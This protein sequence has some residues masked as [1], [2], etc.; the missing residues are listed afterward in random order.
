MAGSFHVRMAESHVKS[1]LNSNRSTVRMGMGTHHCYQSSE[2]DAT[3]NQTK[4]CYCISF[5]TSLGTVLS[6]LQCALVVMVHARTHCFKCNRA[7]LGSSGQETEATHGDVSR[8]WTNGIAS[9][10]RQVLSLQLFPCKSQIIVSI[11]DM[12]CAT[13]GQATRP[14]PVLPVPTQ[15]RYTLPPL[16]TAS[17]ATPPTQICS[18][19]NGCLSRARGM[20]LTRQTSS[21][22]WPSRTHHRVVSGESC[23]WR[24]RTQPPAAVPLA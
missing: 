10:F 2:G 23:H 16:P 4:N 12:C 22:T 11:R 15:S 3:D 7:P 8:Q 20:R 13:C 21:G 9:G 19:P 17:T 18:S 14:P 24:G 1:G 6:K 5:L